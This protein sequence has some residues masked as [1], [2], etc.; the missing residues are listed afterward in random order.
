MSRDRILELMD[1]LSHFLCLTAFMLHCQLIK[2][3]T[4]AVNAV[5]TICPRV[6]SSRTL[7]HFQSTVLELD[8]ITLGSSLS[9][10]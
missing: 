2:D 5:T 1:G 7:R 10:T 8:V 6:T 9:F 4:L 3:V